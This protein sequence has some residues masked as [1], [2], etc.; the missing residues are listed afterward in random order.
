MSREDVGRLRARFEAFGRGDF[1]EAFAELAPSFEMHDHGLLRSTT[2]RAGIE[3]ATKIGQPWTVRDGQ[4]VRL[5]VLPTWDAAVAAAG[6]DSRGRET[7]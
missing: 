1:E 7:A 5:D 3:L 4:A 2:R 6:V